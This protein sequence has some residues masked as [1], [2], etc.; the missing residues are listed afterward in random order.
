MYHQSDPIPVN[1]V[2][3]MFI[4]VTFFALTADYQS[5]KD[6]STRPSSIAMYSC[7]AH[8]AERQAATVQLASFN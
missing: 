4:L 7:L 1:N 3:V 8:L 2:Y 5:T 6:R